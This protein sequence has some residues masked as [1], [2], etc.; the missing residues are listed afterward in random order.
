MYTN[1]NLID[2]NAVVVRLKQGLILSIGTV[3][4]SIRTCTEISCVRISITA[5]QS[6]SEVR[7]VVS[8]S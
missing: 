5:R 6:G 3:N 1:D 8:P 7:L 4:V 2:I